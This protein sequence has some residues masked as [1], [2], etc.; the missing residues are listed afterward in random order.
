MV[1]YGSIRVADLF[2]LPCVNV[3]VILFALSNHFQFLFV[4]KVSFQKRGQT[5]VLQH[6]L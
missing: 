5:S 3:V 2:E 4:C 1:D 6:V